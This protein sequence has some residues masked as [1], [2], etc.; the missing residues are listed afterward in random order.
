MAKVGSRVG[1]AVVSL[2][3]RKDE[4]N[5]VHNLRRRWCIVGSLFAGMPV[6]S[7]VL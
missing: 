3:T 4:S 5:G 2:A 6:P 7:K 1:S